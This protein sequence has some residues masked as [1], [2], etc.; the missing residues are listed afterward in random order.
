[1]RGKD[2][3]SLERREDSV[4]STIATADEK[5]LAFPPEELGDCKKK[6][7]PAVADE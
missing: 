5:L 4:T 2:A 7:L 3:R 6:D 1:M